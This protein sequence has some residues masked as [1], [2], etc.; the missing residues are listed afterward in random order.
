MESLW[1]GLSDMDVARA[2]MGQ[3]WPFAAGPR[4]N[5]EA[6]EPRRSR[7]RMS[8]LDLLVSFG[9]MPKETRSPERN[10]AHRQLGN[11]G[12]LILEGW[13][14]SIIFAGMARSHR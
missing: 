6:R 8:G 11:A 5:D 14:M 1:R 12:G 7:G 4:N 10:R 13:A 9:A 2:A 3:G